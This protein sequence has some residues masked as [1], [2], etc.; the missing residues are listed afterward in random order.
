MSSLKDIMDVD[1]EPFESQAYR[2]SREA[3]EQAARFLVAS[4]SEAPASPVADINRSKST[5]KRRRSNQVSKTDSQ[6]EAAQSK[7]RRRSSVTGE[8]MDFTSG[9]QAGESNQASN[10]GSPQQSPRGSDAAVDMPVKYT[11]VTG[12]ISRAKKGVPVH[13]CD[14]CRPI[15]TFTRAEH[16]RRHQLSH[17]KPAYPCTFEDCERAF[18]RPDLL[19][20]HLQRHE[21]QGEKPYEAGDP[22][23]RASSTDT[24]NRTPDLKVETP[25]TLGNTMQISPIDSMTP[26]TSRSGES[27]MTAASFNTITRSFQAVNFSPSSGYKRSASQAQLPESE[28]Y[29]ATSPGPGPS[30]QAG[31]FDRL[32]GGNFVNDLQQ[33]YDDPFVDSGA[34]QFPNYTTTPPQPPLPLL[35]IPE[36]NW[37]PGLSYSNSPWC[38]SASDSTYSVQSD[39]FSRDRSQSL[40]TLADWPVSAGTHWSPHGLSATPHEIR[41]PAGFD[42]GLERFESP[43]A[44]PRMSSPITSRGQLL[45]VPNTYGSFYMDTVGTP[46]PKYL[47]K[48]VAQHIPAS[49]AR[50]TNPG[51][52][53]HGKKG[54]VEPIHLVTSPFITTSAFQQSL[55]Q[56]DIYISSYWQS[57]NSLFC[58]VHQPTFDLKPHKLL[59][60]SMAAIGTQFHNSPEARARGIEL[61]E[62]CKKEIELVS[63]P[64]LLYQIEH[65]R[66][67]LE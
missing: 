42:S 45:D 28:L 36:E 47:S 58:I 65:M 20:R 66:W 41:S 25:A 57:F 67:D 18:H 10:S 60:R 19:A 17:Q 24:E 33:P 52:D 23:S 27:S 14:I 3:Q 6:A 59:R 29:S 12:R 39:L 13:T 9:Y 46:L 50:T 40:A 26:R 1:V 34:S 5:I 54:M 4:S 49:P 11:P 61:N 31:S 16:L 48:P 64:K 38:S 55:P 53:F 22:S 37:I 51:L 21:T 32:S 43:F 7:V 56:L 63:I 44:S 30:R 8:S 2:R 62:Y 35:R 15:K